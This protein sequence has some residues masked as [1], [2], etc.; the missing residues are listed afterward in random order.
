MSKPLYQKKLQ[1]YEAILYKNHVDLYEFNYHAR[2][3]NVRRLGVNTQNLIAKTV[4]DVRAYL[5]NDPE[6]RQ[7]LHF[8]FMDK[9]KRKSLENEVKQYL[10]AN[11]T[12]IPDIK[13]EQLLEYIMYDL[14]GFG[15]IQPLIDRED[16][17]D[18]FING[19]KEIRYKDVDGNDYIY[20]SKF[21][22]EEELLALAYKITNTAGETFSTAKPWAECTFPFIR[23]SISKSD[24]S[25]LGT[26]ITI[27][28]A[29][30]Y[31]R[32]TEERLIETGQAT[33][34]ML[35]LIRAAVEANCT[36]LICGPTG[37]GKTEF[38]KYMAQFIPDNE[39]TFVAED[40]SELFLEL[41]YPEKHIF[42]KHCRRTGD[43]ETTID[44]AVLMRLGLRE[45][46]KR[47][48]LGE[49]RGAEAWEMIEFFNTGHGG[50]T[51]IHA[52]DAE[53]AM[54]RLVQM[55]QRSDENIMSEHTLYRII[56]SIFD[57]VIVLDV[58]D[59]KRRIVEISEPIGYEN[60]QIMMNQIF[61]FERE[62]KR[63]GYLSDRLLK[64][65]EKRNLNEKLYKSLVS[66]SQEVMQVV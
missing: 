10:Q 16:I 55:C 45:F 4:D 20:H 26:S 48:I 51:G 37:C 59:G 7:L 6:K 22:T 17:T 64:K 60:G 53:Q 54:D 5:I 25:N 57:L 38:M 58:I 39:R 1:E 66:P 32:A 27:R 21:E 42:S 8:S 29:A 13:A 56:T 31:L 52:P 30:P 41:L 47:L 65:L 23:I 49:S 9:A 3:K 33:K 14:T 36:M 34:E 43:K 11:K 44:L 63:R 35:N 2:M 40:D 28:K 46:P 24:I 50:Y 18:I 19:R 61:K 15:M 62:H 12:V